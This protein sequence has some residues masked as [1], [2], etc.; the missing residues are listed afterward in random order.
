MMRHETHLPPQIGE[1][2]S[3]TELDLRENPISLS[4]QEKIHSWLP[5][6]YIRF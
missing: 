5:E 3:L 2:K 6:C 4:E 1:L